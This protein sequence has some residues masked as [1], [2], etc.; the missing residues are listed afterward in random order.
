M[1]PWLADLLK[2]P[3]CGS[4]APLHVNGD[5]IQGE[6]IVTG[7]LVCTECTNTY[8]IRNGIPRFVAVEDD[9]C[10]NFGYQWQQWKELQVDRLSGHN[11]SE[12]RFFKD[13]GWEK[14]WMKDKLILDAG[15]G[16]GRFADVALSHG[17]RVVALDLSEA[18]DACRSITETHGANATWVQGSLL[19]LP[20]REG[21]FDAV[22]CMGV[23]Q[24]T[25]DPQAVMTALPAL[26]KPGGRLM[27]NFYE[28]GLWRRLQVFK[29]G[30]RLITPHLPIGVTL[31]LSRFLVALLFHLTKL[32]AH[33]PKL[34]ILNHFIPIAS[35]HE[36]ALTPKQQYTWTL[37][38]T[39]DW[40][41][42]RFE[43]R[44]HH[45]QVKQLLERLGLS[46]VVSAPGIA[47][48]FK[49]K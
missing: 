21:V 31:G 30:L 41:G 2:C 43:K 32:L 42:A 29:Y 33:V 20:F 22:Y 12:T 11:I 14:S 10:K 25:P 37:L 19:S 1:R 9:Y 48:G 38:D 3:A 49:T 7:A 47:R 4:K 24:H 26:V 36:K 6:D 39:F 40:Y 17:A 16:A 45:N 15:C 44:Q 27:Y 28:E 8:P 13:T 23:I 35:V 34:R 18:I 5:Q 46:E